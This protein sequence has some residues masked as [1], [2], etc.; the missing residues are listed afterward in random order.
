MYD[1][2]GGKKTDL[3]VT[4]YDQPIGVSVTRAFAWP[5][6][7]PYLEADALEDVRDKLTDV[8]L[9]S[10]NVSDEDAWNRQILYILAWNAQHADAVV[11]AYDQ[12]SPDTKSSTLVWVTVTSGT[13]GF[14]YGVDD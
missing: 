8:L 1:T 14:V 5:G 2:P 13:D 10:D 4:M 6:D 12:I 11:A 9:S 7:I 3:L